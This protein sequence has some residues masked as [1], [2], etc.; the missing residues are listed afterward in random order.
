MNYDIKQWVKTCIKCQLATCGKTTTEPLHPLTPVPALHRCSL[1]FIGQLPVTRNGNRWI[2]VAIN[3]TTKWPIAKATQNLKHEM[4]AQF[5]YEEIVFKFGCPVEILTDRGN[6]FTTTM[7]N[8]YYTLIS[9]KHILTS[10]YHPRSN[11]VIERFNRLFG[12]ML[13]KYVG[14]ND[15]NKWDEYIDRALFACRVRQH[16]A[17]GK[18]PFYMVYGVEAKLPG[19]ELIPIINDDEDNNITCRVQQLGQLVQQRDTVHQRLNSNA[20]KMKIYYD[21]HLKHVADKL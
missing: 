2:L 6:N 17:T 4:V 16:H 9:I 20:I 3:H 21:H 11:G 8:S 5:V 7:L 18:T 15:I 10:A 1:D 13:A 12:G 14:D 19:D